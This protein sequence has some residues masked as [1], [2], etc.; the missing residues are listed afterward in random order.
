MN[1]DLERTL[2]DSLQRHAAT[3]DRPNGHIDD[4]Y[5]RVDRRRSRRRS[6]A[7][8]GSVA[9]VGAGIVGIAALAASGSDPAPGAGG[10]EGEQTTTTVVPA[11]GSAWACTGYLG[12]DGFNELYSSCV[13]TA[14]YDQS[15]QPCLTAPPT[16][17]TSTVLLDPAAT[18][19]AGIPVSTQPPL[20]DCSAVFAPTTA[21]VPIDTTPSSSMITVI[22]CRDVDPSISTTT[23][24]PTTTAPATDAQTHVVVAGDSLFGIAA[25]YGID[26]AIL[27]NFN[28]W[29]DCLDHPIYVGDIVQIPPGAR[30]PG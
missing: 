5:A 3:G 25:M 23:S 11:G 29:P 13:P 27:A 19:P 26:P 18:V 30:V 16:V 4:V 14:F 28:S 9:V 10:I 20:Y 6:I 15:T 21:P 17:P 12:S 1:D 2:R 22:D 8:L 7:A 24:P